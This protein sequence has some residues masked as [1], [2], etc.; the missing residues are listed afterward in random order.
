MLVLNKPTFKISTD[1][2]FPF[3]QVFDVRNYALE[4]ASAESSSTRL[5]GTASGHKS[6]EDSVVV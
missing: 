2:T 5:N 1:K 6:R 3:I 4:G